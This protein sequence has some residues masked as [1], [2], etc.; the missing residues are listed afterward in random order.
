MLAL[1]KMQTMVL[2]PSRAPPGIASRLESKSSAK[3]CDDMV[4]S[5]HLQ[6]RVRP[7]IHVPVVASLALIASKMLSNLR[8][9]GITFLARKAWSATGY[10]NP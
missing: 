7:V 3:C 6:D 10:G 8:D 4:L 1:Q 9:S 5:S 2:T